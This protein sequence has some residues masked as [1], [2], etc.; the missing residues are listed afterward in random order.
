MHYKFMV[1]KLWA[2][3]EYFI[4]LLWTKRPFFGLVS[5]N[6]VI[7]GD[8]THFNV[9]F[10]ILLQ[11]NLNTLTVVFLSIRLITF[12]LIDLIN[13]VSHFLLTSFIF[14]FLFPSV[15]LS[16]DV[17][18]MH[19]ALAPARAPRAGFSLSVCPYCWHCCHTHVTWIILHVHLSAST[20][21]S[22]T[23]L[24]IHCDHVCLI[25]DLLC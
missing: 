17:S 15:L 10:L 18:S 19:A 13:G 1:S 9:C 3:T 6:Q 24:I 21:L 7:T 20:S 8:Y 25:N 4:N 22:V 23:P 14:F 12:D 11:G 2:K 5:C 16:S